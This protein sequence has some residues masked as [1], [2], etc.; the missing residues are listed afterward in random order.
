VKRGNDLGVI[1]EIL[2]HAF[3][4]IRSDSQY[5]AQFSRIFAPKY[6]A[7]TLRDL[8]LRVSA[9]PQTPLAS[10]DTFYLRHL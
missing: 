10:P 1:F 3:P 6:F 2:S 4:P 5:A 7:Q 9:L 8:I